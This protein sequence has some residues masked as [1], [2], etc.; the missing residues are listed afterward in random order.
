MNVK[1]GGNY[2]GERRILFIMD[3]ATRKFPGDI[4]L[5]IQYVQ[6]AQKQKAYKKVIQ[7]L[8]SLVR[9]HPT[10]PE[11]WTYAAK[12]AM[13]EHADMTEARSYMQRGLR[14]CKQSRQ[15]W[16]DYAKLELIYVAKIAARRSILG[17][18][19]D[20]T[21]KSLTSAADDVD[22]NI[23]KLPAITAEDI[24]PSLRTDQDVD[25]E[26]LQAFSKTPALSGAIPM[27]I[28]DAAMDYFKDER[29]GAEFFEMVIDMKDVACAK[30]ILE[31]IVNVLI[32]TT[33]NSPVS[34]DASIRLPLVG[35]PI[36]SPLF[37]KALQTAL[38]RLRAGTQSHNSAELCVK[39]AGWISE[40]L[41]AVDLDQDIRTVLSSILS[42]TIAHYKSLI[43]QGQGSDRETAQLLEKARSAQLLTA[44]ASLDQLALELWPSSKVLASLRELAPSHVLALQ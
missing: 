4:P 27:A 24:D 5:W 43:K 20:W 1:G 18:D 21:D 30:P 42:K 26:E 6:V 3:R 17:L 35:I 8:T 19:M 12:Y 32:T 11:V 25:E 14:F 28:F 13:E 7:I 44:A 39:T 22:A 16:L 9:L 2:A 40:Y 15:L 37:P 29:L 41:E 34:L 38:D 10:K 23:V 31:H 33:P 36:S